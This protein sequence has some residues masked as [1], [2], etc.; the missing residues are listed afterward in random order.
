MSWE[1]QGKHWNV[2][3]VKPCASFDLEDAEEQEECFNWKNLQPLRA[4]KNKS[5]GAK[6]D[7]FQIMLQELKSTVFLKLLEKYVA[8]HSIRDSYF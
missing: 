1:N 2:D 4:D 5:K 3:H 7:K 6:I 8:K